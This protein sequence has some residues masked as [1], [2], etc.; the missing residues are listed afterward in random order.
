VQVHYDGNGYETAR[1]DPETVPANLVPDAPPVWS[2]RLLSLN[3]AVRRYA[4]TRAWQVR[5]T[6]ALEYDFL[7]GIAAYLERQASLALVGSGPRGTG[8][9]ITE[10]NATPTMGFLEGRT[11]GE[12]YLLVLH[13]AAFELRPPEEDE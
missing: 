3:E 5:H 7:H 1:R 6:N 13:L 11:R 10:R 2:G 8:P 12:R 4:F 9:L